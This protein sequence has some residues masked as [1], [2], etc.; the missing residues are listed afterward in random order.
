M[1]SDSVPAGSG[2][3][4]EAI[5]RSPVTTGA[6]LQLPGTNS[7]VCGIRPRDPFLLNNDFLF[8][9]L[10][11][12]NSN[13]SPAAAEFHRPPRPGRWLLRPC[14]PFT[15]II[16][17]RLGTRERK[18]SDTNAS[19]GGW[20]NRAPF[21]LASF[22]VSSVRFLYYRL[23]LTPV[24][25]ITITVSA[26]AQGDFV[27]KTVFGE[28]AVFLGARSWLVGQATMLVVEF[29]RCFGGLRIICRV[30]ARYWRV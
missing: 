2:G 4:D 16:L 28:A 17:A 5:C 21:L 3:A 19:K 10:A 29:F 24:I 20:K 26:R 11:R 23:H 22:L 25:R 30:S 8:T 14:T 7:Y 12:I 9:T 27:G 1:G 18:G 6:H 13:G 15:D